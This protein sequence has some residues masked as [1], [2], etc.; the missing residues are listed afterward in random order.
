MFAMRKSKKCIFFG[1]MMDSRIRKHRLEVAQSNLPFRSFQ[2]SFRLFPPGLRMGFTYIILF[3]DMVGV[4]HGFLKNAQA[5]T[6]GCDVKCCC[7]T[8]TTNLKKRMVRTHNIH[9]I[10]HINEFSSYKTCIY[11]FL[12]QSE[13][14]IYAP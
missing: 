9:I 10:N 7:T 5:R 4:N 14:S 6:F 2:A 3:Y 1:L 8:H 13:N 12:K 11:S